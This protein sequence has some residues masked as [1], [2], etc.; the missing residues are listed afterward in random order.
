LQTG[1]VDTFNLTTQLTDPTTTAIFD[2]ME[3]NMA[4]QEQQVADLYHARL[5]DKKSEAAKPTTGA[6]VTA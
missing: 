1:V 3:V 2:E 6:A 4:K 5:G